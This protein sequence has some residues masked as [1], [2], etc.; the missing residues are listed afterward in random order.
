MLGC[1]SDY[2]QPIQF[3]VDVDLNPNLG[4]NCSGF[5]NHVSLKGFW[6]SLLYPDIVPQSKWSGFP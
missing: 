2:I 1:N 3:E 4:A 5:H 6:D